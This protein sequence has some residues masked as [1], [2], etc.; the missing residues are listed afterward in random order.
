MNLGEWL[1]LVSRNLKKAW[2]VRDPKGIVSTSA[3]VVYFPV[4][5]A[6]CSSIKMLIAQWDEIDWDGDIHQAPFATIRASQLD[7]LQGYRS[8]MIVRNPWS[9][10]LSAYRDKIVG[11]QERHGEI[12]DGLLRY[13]RILGRRVFW[14]GMQFSDFVRAV[15]GIPDFMADEHF[16]SQHRMASAPGSGLVVDEWI[17]L[18]NLSSALDVFLPKHLPRPLDLP[19]ANRTSGPDYHEM[20]TD[21]L[22]MDVEER[23]RRDVELFGYAF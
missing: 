21:E 12:H 10:I 18:E 20:Y 1:K 7:Q 23:Y 6:A 19:M 4:P 14:S 17:R 3:R 15:R 8:F 22:V 5:K 9:R 11:G 16:R 2:D 13:N